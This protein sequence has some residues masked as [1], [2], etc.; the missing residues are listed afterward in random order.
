MKKPLP[1]KKSILV[2]EDE[3]AL[4]DVV[5]KRL[6]KKGFEVITARSV[7][8]VFNATLDDN[9]L[10]IISVSSIQQAL[11][12][13]EDLENVD[14]IWLDHNLLGKENGIDFV[15][16]LKANGGK[17]QNIPIFVVSNTEKSGTIQ[18]YVDL[19]VSKYYIKSNHKLDEIIADINTTLDSV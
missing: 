17:W 7:D 5:N 15:K 3:R 12:Y 16:K 9:G 1:K 8:E 14:A 11:D 18:S 13:L 4:L 2:I 6:G 10:G 19:G